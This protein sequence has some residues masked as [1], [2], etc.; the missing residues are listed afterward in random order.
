[1]R[2]NLK[3]AAVT[4]AFLGVIALGAIGSHQLGISR[5][6]QGDVRALERQIEERCR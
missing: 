1:M 6:T 4:L 5:A 3:T 2:D